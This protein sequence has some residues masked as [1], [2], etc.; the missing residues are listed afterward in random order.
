MSEEVWYHCVWCDTWYQPLLYVKQPAY[1]PDNWC[2]HCYEG[3]REQFLAYTIEQIVELRNDL[4]RRYTGDPIPWDGVTRRT[5]YHHH[6][7]NIRHNELWN[8]QILELEL[9]DR[10]YMAEVP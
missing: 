1:R 2:G 7:H 5:K 9:A 6:I 10:F 8:I 4:R 3:R